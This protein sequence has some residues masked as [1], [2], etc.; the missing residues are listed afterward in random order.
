MM[1]GIRSLVILLIAC[2]TAD[3]VTQNQDMKT[4]ET[5]SPQISPMDLV[6]TGTTMAIVL[7]PIHASFRMWIFAASKKSVAM[8]LTVVSFSTLE[9]RSRKTLF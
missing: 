2:T 5:I 6:E 8:G 1:F 3:V 7:T 4:T 9:A